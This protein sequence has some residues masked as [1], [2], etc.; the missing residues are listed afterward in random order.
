MLRRLLAPLLGLVL[1]AAACGGPETAQPSGSASEAAGS[2][3]YPR[4]GQASR[5]VQVPPSTPDPA[6][7]SRLV[8]STSAGDIPVVLDAEQAPCTV[9]SFVSLARQGFFT[10]T[11]CH[12]LTSGGV[13]TLQCGDPSASGTGGPGYTVPGELVSNDPR[14]SPCASS[15]AACTYAN[16]YLALAASGTSGDGGSQFFLVYRG[17]QLPPWYTVF[18]HTNAS[19]LK[20]LQAIGD[21]GTADGSVDGPPAEPVTITDVR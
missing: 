2:C 19:G 14:L 12:R 7:P 20:V 8:I 6:N 9:N 17:S 13:F 11:T 10:S 3:T 1:V 15:G 5:P 18:G 21:R 16:G 4:A